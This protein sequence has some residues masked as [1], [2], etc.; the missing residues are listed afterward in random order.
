MNFQV[1]SELPLL[2]HPPFGCCNGEWQ[3]TFTDTAV[4]LLIVV[5]L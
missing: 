5:V 4:A 3:V 2:L 1:I